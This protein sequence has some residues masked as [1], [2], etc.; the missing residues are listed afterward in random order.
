MTDRPLVRFGLGDPSHGMPVSRV[1][2]EAPS[3]L[4]GKSADQGR[5]LRFRY[6]A[7][8]MDHWYKPGPRSPVVPAPI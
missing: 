4:A 1:A 7:V 8:S 2:P 3:K 6:E 5:T